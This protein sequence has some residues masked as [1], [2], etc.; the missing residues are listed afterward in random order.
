MCRLRVVFKPAPVRSYLITNNY[1]ST[2]RRHKGQGAIP[3]RSLKRL[4]AAP[5]RPTRPLRPPDL[6]EEPF[7]PA[8]GLGCQPPAIPDRPFIAPFVDSFD[9]PPTI[10]VHG[11]SRRSDLR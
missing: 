7:R 9:R 6:A 8:E 11:L 10:R 3:A 5:L 1:E 4:H 2:Q